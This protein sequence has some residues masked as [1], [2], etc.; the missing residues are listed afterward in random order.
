MTALFRT[1][2]LL[3]L[4]VSPAFATRVERLIDN[5]RPEHY[6]LDITLDDRL[7]A[8]TSAT[9]QVNVLIVK[10]TSLIDFDFGEMTTDSVTLNSKSVQ[11]AHKDGKLNITLPSA[12]SPGT[13]LTLVINYHGK[14]KDGLVLTNDKDGKPAAVGDN[15]PNRVHHWIPALDHPAAKATITFN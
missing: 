4:L 2:F 5:W 11:F 8:I 6:I 10:Q 12:A 13:H 9:A 7:S 3:V 1:I 14:P 15:W